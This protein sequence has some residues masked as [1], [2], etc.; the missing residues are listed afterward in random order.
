MI[1]GVEKERA[2]KEVVEAI[3]R[4]KSATLEATEGK[5]RELEGACTLAE[6]KAAN[7][8]VKFREI[9]LRLAEAE[10]IILAKD[11]EVADLKVAMEESEN[12]FYDLGFADAENSSDPIMFQS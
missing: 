10:S 9:E 5:A 1:E 4:E 6:Q 7:L 12:K 3:M 8:E 2:F 11:K